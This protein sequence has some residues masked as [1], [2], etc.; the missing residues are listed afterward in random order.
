I[1]LFLKRNLD[2]IRQECEAPAN[3]PG[4]Q[5]IR[6]LVRKAGGLFIWVATTCRFV[7]EGKQFAEERLSLI[8]QCDDST[9]AP[10]DQLNKIYITVLQSFIGSNYTG[11]EKEYLCKRLRVTLGSIVLLFSPLSAVC[12]AKLLNIAK[13]VVKKTLVDLHSILDIPED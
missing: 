5:A 9:T 7:R 11:Q 13:E 10:E 1:S 4:E 6:S 2:E 3:W 8:L 12:L